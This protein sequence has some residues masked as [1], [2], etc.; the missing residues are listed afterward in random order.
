LVDVTPFRFEADRGDR[1]VSVDEHKATWRSS[2]RGKVHGISVRAEL[3]PR[4]V[5]QFQAPGGQRAIK[6]EEIPAA[7]PVKFSVSGRGV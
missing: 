2:A 4:S 5:L 6:A 1:M 3:G 7:G